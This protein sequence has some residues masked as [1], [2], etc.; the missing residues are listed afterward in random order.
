MAPPERWLLDR[1]AVLEQ[2]FRLNYRSLVSLAKLLVDHQGDAEEVVQ[3]AFVGAYTSWERLRSPDDPL[4]YLR[5]SVVNLSRGR[6]RRRRTRR[7]T[8][9]LAERLHH[10]VDERVL[11]T[12]RQQRIVEALRD[13]PSRQRE[14]VALRYLLDCTTEQTAQT[15]G[16]APGSV[17]SHLHRALHRLEHQLGDLR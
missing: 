7:T 5:T 3:D 8:P 15:L 17:K 14:V 4:P 12:E 2:A 9:L 6:L 1:D 10:D 16:I 11:M 13:L